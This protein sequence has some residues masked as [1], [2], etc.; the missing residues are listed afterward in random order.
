MWYKDEAAGSHTFAADSTDLSR[1][2][3]HGPVI[4]DCPHEGPNVFFWKGVYWM[5]TDPWQ[6]LGA[7]RSDDAESWTRQENILDRPGAR[8]DDGN[9]DSH[10]DVLV[11][12]DHAYAARRSSIQV[13]ELELRDGVLRCDRDAQVS[14]DLKAPIAPRYSAD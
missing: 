1:W 14:V 9:I 3:V 6:G 2:K 12:G 13:A 11:Q 10:A 7:Y 5:I 4:T 8:R